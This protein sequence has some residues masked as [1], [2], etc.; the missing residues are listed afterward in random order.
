M[1][2]ARKYDFDIIDPKHMTMTQIDLTL[3]DKHLKKLTK[4]WKKTLTLKAL[5]Q[6]RSGNLYDQLRI[7]LEN[8][9]NQQLTD[10][11][12]DQFNDMPDDTT[13]ICYP[14]RYNIYSKFVVVQ[15]KP[16]L[17]FH[18]ILIP[19]IK[20]ALEEYFSGGYGLVRMGKFYRDN[21]NIMLHISLAR[22]KPNQ[23]IRSTIIRS[24]QSK[25]RFNF[26]QSGLARNF[27]IS[28]QILNSFNNP[29]W[30]SMGSYGSF[31]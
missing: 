22:E 17:G 15:Y 28:G 25:D 29:L 30:V 21:K 20:E 9:L 6:D 24:I 1:Q 14:S 3:T 19:V 10:V 16:D 4:G 26:I 11:L 2:I 13:A 7:G 8:D 23:K 18:A 31:N 12:M 27:V 5:S